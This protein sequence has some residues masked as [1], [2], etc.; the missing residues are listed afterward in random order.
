MPCHHGRTRDHRQPDNR[1]DLSSIGRW[2]LHMVV[3]ITGV[4]QVT[5][6]ALTEQARQYVNVKHLLA[7]VHDPW[8]VEELLRGWVRRS[9]TVSGLAG[10]VITIATMMI[11]LCEHLYEMR[12]ETRVYLAGIQGMREIQ[13]I[14]ANALNLEVLLCLHRWSLAG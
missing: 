10:N 4:L 12:H 3:T 6:D 13:G 2:K 11:E 9:S 7:D 14:N 5:T 1:N 8:L